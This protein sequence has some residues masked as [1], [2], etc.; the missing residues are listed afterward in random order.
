MIVCSRYSVVSL[1]QEVDLN[2]FG[3]KSNG[4]GIQIVSIKRGVFGL[5]FLLTSNYCEKLRFPIR[6]QEC[7][8]ASF[9]R[10]PQSILVIHQ[11]NEDL[12]TLCIIYDIKIT[13]CNNRSS[14]LTLIHHMKSVVI[15]APSFWKIW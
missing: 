7:Y 6:I 12:N 11:R 5:K 3:I 13:C 1:D 2:L 10:Y 14:H 9:L 4:S 15:F 8:R